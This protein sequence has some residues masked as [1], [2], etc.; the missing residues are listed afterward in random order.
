MKNYEAMF[1][2]RSDS[3]KDKTK[4]LFNQINDL[5]SKNRASVVDSSV[6]AEAR[7]LAFII[8]KH[9]QGTYFLVNFKS[10]PEAV[11]KIYRDSRLNEDILRLMITRL[12][13]EK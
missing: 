6:W 11:S 13:K 4:V 9:N 2:L 3:N 1:I 12:E 8:K 10:D 7:K 5:F